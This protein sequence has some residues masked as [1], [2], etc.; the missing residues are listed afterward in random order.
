MLLSSLPPACRP[1]CNLAQILGFCQ[2]Q[3]HKNL[4]MNAPPHSVVTATK[5]KFKHLFKAVYCVG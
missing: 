1:N 4:E 3:F 2:R 5:C